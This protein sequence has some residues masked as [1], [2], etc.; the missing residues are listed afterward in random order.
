MRA[1]VFNIMQYMN[2]PDTGVPLL[3]EDTIK[4]GLAHKSVKEWAYILH[5]KDVYSEADEEADPNHKQGGVKPPHWHIVL[6]CPSGIE[7]GTIAKWL[8]IGE[9]FVDVPK[10]RGAFLDCIEYI[11]HEAEKQQGLGKHRYDD[12]EVHSNFDFRGRLTQRTENELKY[13]RDLSPLKRMMYDVTYLGKT[14]RQ[15]QAEDRQMYMENVEKLRRLRLEYLANQEAPVQRLNFYLTGKG[16][17]GKDLMSRA[18]ARAL[19]PQYEKDADIFF[20]VGSG[21]VT[22]EGYDGQPVLIWPDR[23]AAG[24]LKALGGRENV[25]N[26]F[27][28]YPTNQ[29]QNVKYGS[30]NLCNQVNIVNG[31]EPFD[32]F[33][34]G[35]AGQYTD[36][37]G[38]DWKAEDKS[39]SYRRFPFII[40]IRDDEFDLWV[41]RGFMSNDRSQFLDYDK[42][43]HIR[44]SFARLAQQY[45]ENAISQV[46]ANKMLGTVLEQVDKAREKV[47]VPE[48][49]KPTP[50]DVLKWIQENG[51]G[52][53]PTEA[54][55]RIIDSMQDILSSLSDEDEEIPFD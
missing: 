1:R 51:Y 17:V 22:F 9:N 10:G 36:R 13:G 19:F 49:K 28:T 40:P 45:G 31:Q 50:E 2:H 16:G 4:V 27:D 48:D 14:L 38:K 47:E 52:Q 25:F 24:L 18:L 5:D 8:G 15:C 11:T 12:S 21:Q 30:V 26:V 43:N 7:V 29:K 6:Q 32:E 34:D 39:Q 35:L 20:I 3:N 44:G 42:Y 23:R 37:D 55:Q 54:Q 41:N 53:M 33:L 46:G